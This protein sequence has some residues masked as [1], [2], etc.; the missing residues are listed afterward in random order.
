MTGGAGELRPYHGC[1]ARD[2]ER[3]RCGLTYHD[4]RTGLTFAEV[5]A[6]MWRAAPPWRYRRRH[7]VLGYWRQ[8][9][10]AAW[11]IHVAECGGRL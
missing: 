3:C 11:A 10:L 5:R 8:L 4:F 9:K 1:E 7:G 2:P 6:Q